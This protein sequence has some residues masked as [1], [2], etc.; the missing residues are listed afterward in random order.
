MND[1]LNFDNMLTPKII[2]FVYWILLLGAV[3]GGLGSIFAGYGGFS[4]GKF[5]M[6]ILYTVGGAVAA[7]IW[8]ELMI[9][10]FKINEALQEIRQK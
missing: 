6:G 7:R 2:T 5:F 8:C 3:V 9:V 1:I 4:I 10:A